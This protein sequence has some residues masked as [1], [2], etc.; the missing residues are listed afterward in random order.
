MQVGQID[1]K[2]GELRH[3]ANVGAVEAAMLN[4]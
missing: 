3:R 4:P 1:A 2:P